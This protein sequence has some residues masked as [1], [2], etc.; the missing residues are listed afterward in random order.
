MVQGE[1][2]HQLNK[3]KRPHKRW[4]FSP[5]YP[6]PNR[7]TSPQDPLRVE[8]LLKTGNSEWGRDDFFRSFYRQNGLYS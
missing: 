1:K 3:S 5:W 7:H 2:G 8:E 4:N 6:V